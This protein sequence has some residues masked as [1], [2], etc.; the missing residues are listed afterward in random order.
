M[1][2]NDPAKDGTISF[3]YVMAPISSVSKTKILEKKYEEFNSIRKIIKDKNAEIQKLKDEI[4]LVP[5]ELKTL[6]WFN[7]IMLAY[8][9]KEIKDP[10]KYSIVLDIKKD[11]KFLSDLNQLEWPN[12]KVIEIYPCEIDV[13][14]NDVIYDLFTKNFP[15]SV[16][17][18]KFWYYKRKETN[19]HTFVKEIV[20]VSSK[21]KDRLI[22][23]NTTVDVE[24]LKLL[25]ENMNHLRV[26]SFE[27]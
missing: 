24:C 13:K 19:I 1:R 16:N 7:S 22:I 12:F 26:L 6:C 11:Y 10:E 4:D 5:K 15:D 8:N 21:I 18:L 3:K 27:R 17:T 25:I 2:N 9:K 14:K 20:S 23:S